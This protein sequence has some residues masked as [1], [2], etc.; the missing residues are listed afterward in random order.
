[1]ERAPS[2]CGVVLGWML[3]VASREVAAHLD[4]LSPLGNGFA[5]AGGYV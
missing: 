3:R 5:A 2:G 1:M 4:G